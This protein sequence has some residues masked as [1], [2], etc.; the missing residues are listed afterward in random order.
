[1]KELISISDD[2]SL[3]NEMFKNIEKYVK[4]T[5]VYEIGT[6]R[7]EVDT[8]SIKNEL[9]DFLDDAFTTIKCS[10]RQPIEDSDYSDVSNEKGTYTIS[11]NKYFVEILIF[12]I[13]LEMS[14]P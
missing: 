11:S 5:C 8:L 6:G 10:E 4:E 1:M 2:S 14:L 9:S 13:K 7:I 12:I 3:K